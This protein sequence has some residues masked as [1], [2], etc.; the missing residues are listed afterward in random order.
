MSASLD[1]A[2]YAARDFELA[3]TRVA[4][5]GGRRWDTPGSLHQAISPSV[6]QT[7][8]LELVDR[9]LVALIDGDDID[10]LAVFMAPQEGKS[11]RVS[12]AFALWLLEQDPE[13]RIAIVS[14]S[15][16]MA[17]RH[18]A[19]IKSD[20]QTFNGIDGDLDLGIRLRE[21]SRAAGRWQIEG[22]AGGVYCVGI[23][24][25]LTGKPVD[26][27]IIDDPLKDLEQAQSEA[28]R[29]R[30]MNFWR[31]VAVP[32]LGP[33]AKVVLVQTRWHEKDMGG[34]LLAEEPDRWRVVSIPAVAENVTDPLGREPGEAMVS[35]RGQRDWPAIRRSVGDYV[36]A[37]L[38]QQ[39]PAPAEG[40]LFKRDKFQHWTHTTDEPTGRPS[41]RCADRTVPVDSLWR[42]LT[43]DLAASTRTSADF[44]VAGVW[45]IRPDG[46]LVLLDGLRERLDPSMHWSKIRALR[47]KWDAGTVYVEAAMNATTLVYEAGRAGV[48]ISE[49]KP[50]KDKTTRAIPAAARVD[51]GRLWVP[52]AA[53]APWITDWIDELAAFGG[54]AAHDDVVDVFGYA[55]RVAAA[56]YLVPESDFVL[57]AR[58]IGALAA[59]TQELD[60][61]AI[62]F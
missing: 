30:A 38:Y 20:A 53:V 28:Y 42:F 29:K 45:G 37:A 17:R 24:G 15:D 33:G 32:R 5:Q 19:A 8:A 14:Y 40:G 48:P 3:T 59:H 21:D 51:A 9:E 52:S 23:G 25:S 46:D 12:H 47:A 7:P 13:L 2:E 44:T 58:R 27:L 11:E 31:G 49:L 61:E 62:V 1:W 41:I 34:Q 36:W 10:R 55:A 43:I 18:G 54:G 26:V 57:N 22:H 4:Q 50:D 39:R 35:A 56:H 6:V 16:E 60:F